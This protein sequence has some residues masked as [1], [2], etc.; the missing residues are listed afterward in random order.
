M[1]G[2]DKVLS[3]G[4]NGLNSAKAHNVC[5]QEVLLCNALS[6]GH[7]SHS[8]TP[9][10]LR[11]ALGPATCLQKKSVKKAARWLFVDS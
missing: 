7:W 1:S 11:A 3:H 5:S 6:T 9:S 10:R 4:H 2:R 8:V